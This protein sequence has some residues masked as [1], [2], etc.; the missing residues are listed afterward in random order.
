MFLLIIID[1][2]HCLYLQNNGPNDIVSIPFGTTADTVKINFKAEG[3]NCKMQVIVSII[4]C[5]QSACKYLK[6]NH[7]IPSSLIENLYC[8]L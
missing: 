3:Q 7:S 8:L 5:F 1:V 4:G 2:L 6:F